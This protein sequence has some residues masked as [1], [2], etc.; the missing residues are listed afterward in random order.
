MTPYNP[1]RFPKAL[2]PNTIT[3]RGGWISTCEFVCVCVGGGHTDVQA[4]ADYKPF[5]GRGTSL[6]S[7]SV[8]SNL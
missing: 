6:S 8:L 2:S 1:N 3:L 4:I 5:E 7:R